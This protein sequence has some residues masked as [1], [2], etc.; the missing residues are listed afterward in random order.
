MTPIDAR[1]PRFNQAVVAVALAAGFLLDFRVV[2]PIAAVVLLLSAL[3]VGPLLLLW[4]HAVAPRVSPPR[5]VEDPR[6]PRFAAA[7]GTVFL[8]A[9]A[10]FFAAGAPPLGW[11]LALVVA[12]LAGLAAATGICVA[13][14][15]YVFWRGRT[16]G[17]WAPLS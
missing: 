1:A 13:C 10:V 5:E 11:A 15:V 2:V 3:G 12:A 17:G 4:R 16:R 14:E 6:P 9:S 7:V 8:A